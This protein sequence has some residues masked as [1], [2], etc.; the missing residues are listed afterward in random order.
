MARHPYGPRWGQTDKWGRYKCKERS[1]A[2]GGFKQTKSKSK[3]KT[4]K[5]EKW[6]N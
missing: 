6:M 3:S 5:D 4:N 1:V 2:N